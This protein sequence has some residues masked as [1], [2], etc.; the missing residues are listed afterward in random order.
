MG[1]VTSVVGLDNNTK[2]P[3]TIAGFGDSALS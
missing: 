1:N 2:A 3:R